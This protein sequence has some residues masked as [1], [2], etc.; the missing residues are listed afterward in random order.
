M[1]HGRRRHGATRRGGWARMPPPPRCPL[2][3]S[4]EGW[5]QCAGAHA[6]RASARRGIGA[7]RAVSRPWRGS[8]RRPGFHPTAPRRLPQPRGRPARSRRPR[9]SL[10]TLPPGRPVGCPPLSPSARALA[11]SRSRG[12]LHG[13]G[14]QER[15]RGPGPPWPP[16]WPSFAPRSWQIPGRRP[17]P[18][19]KVRVLSARTERRLRTRAAFV[20]G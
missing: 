14:T 8:D 9:R 18:L 13:T 3:R 6:W 7:G 2:L 17:R 12:C 16:P 4:R 11:D 10:P 20:Y 15:G 1:Q 5:V 19:G